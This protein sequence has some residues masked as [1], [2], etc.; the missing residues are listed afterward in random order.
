MIFL[1]ISILTGILASLKLNTYI[2]LLIS[3]I[4]VF[5]IYFLNKKIIISYIIYV[6]ISIIFLIFT[7]IKIDA[8][9]SKC[10]DKTD[11]IGEFVILSVDETTEY[12]NKYICKNNSGDK[13]ILQ[14]KLSEDTL[15][16][17]N[18]IYLEGVFKLPDLQRNEGGFNYRRY[19]NSQNLYGTITAKNNSIKF[20]N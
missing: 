7:T 5:L 3:I 10:K 14:V 20:Y 12:Y 2:Y 1:L 19:L 17:R 11:I 9:D 13:F 4:S 8:Y 15:N 6:S 18:K 16:V